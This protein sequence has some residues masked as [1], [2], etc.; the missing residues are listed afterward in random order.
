MDV[1]FKKYTVLCINSFLC[2]GTVELKLGKLPLGL[3]S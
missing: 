1:S 3:N 2:G